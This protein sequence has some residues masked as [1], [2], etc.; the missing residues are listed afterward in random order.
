MHTF[1]VLIL[2]SNIT[3]FSSYR[4][5]NTFRLGRKKQSPNAVWGNSN[6]LL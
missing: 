4:A 1:A 3:R 5:V 6:C 2:D